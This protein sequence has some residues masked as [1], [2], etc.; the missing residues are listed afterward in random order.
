[1]RKSAL[2]GDGVVPRSR[3]RSS[4]ISSG[5]KSEHGSEIRVMNGC[6]DLLSP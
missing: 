5:S 6:G 1:M 2:T 4:A 3:H